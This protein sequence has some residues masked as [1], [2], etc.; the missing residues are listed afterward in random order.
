MHKS[1]MQLQ[2]DVMEELHWDPAVR[3]AEVGVAAKD[4]VVTLSGDFDSFAVKAE[5]AAWSAPGVSTVD[6]QL[7]AGA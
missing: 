2:R 7:A 3:G 1:D 5:Q 6:D 4:G